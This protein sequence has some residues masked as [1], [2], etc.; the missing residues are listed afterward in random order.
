[1]CQA[2]TAYQSRRKPLAEARFMDG[3]DSEAASPW[4]APSRG[5]AYEVELRNYRDWISVGLS[6]LLYRELFRLKRLL[7][8]FNSGELARTACLQERK[9]FRQMHKVS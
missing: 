5:Y 4:A 9:G 8:A 6:A 1:V 7:C 2:L 3:Q